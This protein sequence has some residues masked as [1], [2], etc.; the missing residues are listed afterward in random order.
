MPKYVCE[1]VLR[2]FGIMWDM[3]KMFVIRQVKTDVGSSNKQ[4]RAGLKTAKFLTSP[5]LI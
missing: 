4:G 5:S 3:K 2:V 1:P